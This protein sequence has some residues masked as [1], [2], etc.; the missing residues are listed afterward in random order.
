LIRLILNGLFSC[1]KG[2]YN[3]S[4]S[5]VSNLKILN[6]ASNI[7]LTWND[8]TK[9]DY[10]KVE[11]SWNSQYGNLSMAILK[12]VQ[13]AEIKNLVSGKEYIFTVKTVDNNGNKSRGITIIGNPDH[14]NL[15][16]GNYKFKN[17]NHLLVLLSVI[18]PKD[19]IINDTV[20]YNGTIEKYEIDKLKI[21]Y[22]PDYKEPDFTYEAFPMR[23]YVYGLIYPTVNYEG[24]LSYPGIPSRYIFSG[25]FIGKDSIT[26]SFF[27][28]DHFGSE[29]YQMYGKRLIKN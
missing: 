12:G 14:R 6:G 9:E 16:V 7:T 23:G 29:S 13:S 27:H 21:V 22:A 5:E 18:P 24:I 1:E 25:N 10:S 17:F 15:Y 8:P 3:I 4:P 2:V 20:D 11:I 28:Y 26:F 19:T